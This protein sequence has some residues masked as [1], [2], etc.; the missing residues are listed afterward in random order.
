MKMQKAPALV[1]RLKGG[2]GNQMFEYASAKAIAMRNN[3]PLFVD[4]ESGFIGDCYRRSFALDSFALPMNRLTS[5]QA[6]AMAPRSFKTE[7]LR[8]REIL[9]MQWLCDHHDPALHNLRIDAPFLMDNYLQSPVYFADCEGAIRDEFGGKDGSSVEDAVC[10]HVRRNL[11]LTASGQLVAEKF[12]GAYGIEYYRASMDLIRAEFPRAK[13][14]CFGDDPAWIRDNILP[15]CPGSVVAN[16]GSDI[17]DFRSMATC[18]HFII[19]NSTFSWW[20]AWLGRKENGIVCCGTKWNQGER[21]P[22][23][24]FIPADWKRVGVAG[25]P[26]SDSNEREVRPLSPSTL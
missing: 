22:I 11:A 4:V 7:Y 10:V 23:K 15:M 19:A 14:Y 21:G 5:E 9:R 17:A 26:H 25:A 8:R 18:R 1:V 6:R 13:F 2:L 3:V 12:Y 20:A 16:T 24:N